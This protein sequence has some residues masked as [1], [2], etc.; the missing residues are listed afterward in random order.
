MHCSRG[1]SAPRRSGQGS[2]EFQR[3][4]ASATSLFLRFF[5]HSV[6]FQNFTWPS[7]S[8]LWKVSWHPLVAQEILFDFKSLIMAVCVGLS[9][10]DRAP[11]WQ[12]RHSRL[13]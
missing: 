5:R 7:W 1:D 6:G 2:L 9:S 10:N 3:V 12:C 11:E 8:T 13:L 4:A